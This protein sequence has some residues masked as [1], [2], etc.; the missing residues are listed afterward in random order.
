[1]LLFFSLLAND[2]YQNA[3]SPASVELA[4]KNLLPGAEVLYAVCYGYN[5]FASH[6]LTLHMSV[7]IIFTRIVVVIF[8]DRLMWS[9]L[10]QLFFISFTNDFYQ[11]SLAPS[12]I[13]LT[14]KDLFP[15]TKI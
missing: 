14:I 9:K 15:W 10:L 7:G 11:Y 5:S 13:K 2:L 4:I 1:M 3:L 6:D 12:T 8:A